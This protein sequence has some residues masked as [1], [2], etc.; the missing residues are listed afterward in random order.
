MVYKAILRTWTTWELNQEP[1]EVWSLVQTPELNAHTAVCCF[2]RAT[3]WVGLWCLWNSQQTTFMSTLGLILE[4]IF[5]NFS[6]PT[7]GRCCPEDLWNHWSSVQLSARFKTWWWNGNVIAARHGNVLR[8]MCVYVI[9]C[10]WKLLW[11]GNSPD[12]DRTFAGSW[13]YHQEC[14]TFCSASDLD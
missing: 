1:S 2:T 5:R 9:S 8:W 4:V 6:V 7:G 13:K 14:L 3:C 12:V 11:R 10:R